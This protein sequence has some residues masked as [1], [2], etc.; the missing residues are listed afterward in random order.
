MIRLLL[1]LILSLAFAAQSVAMTLP[2][3]TDKSAFT[4][5]TDGVQ[6]MGGCYNATRGG[7]VTEDYASCARITNQGDLQVS[8]TDAGGTTA[9]DSTAHAAKVLVVDSTGTAIT[10]SAI[11][12]EAATF[13]T[14]D[15]NVLKT[16][17]YMFGYNSDS[18]ATQW[19]RFA[20]Q[21]ADFDTG[22]GTENLSLIGIGIP[23]SGGPVIGGTA[24]NPF[25]TS[26]A[27]SGTWTVQPGNTANTTAWLTSVVPPTSGGTSA[28]YITSAATTNATN[29]KASAGQLYGYEAVNTTA[30]LYYLRLYNL[31]SAP[32]CS[33]ATGFIRTIPI[34]ASTTGAGIQRSI[35][36]GEAYGTGIG[37]CL[38][39]GG[40]STDNTSAATGV[41]LTLNYK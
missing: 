33:S 2:F 34:P 11:G 25:S 15:T 35:D 4:E 38:T 16:I 1:P 7:S 30:T 26:A 8:L 37:F 3:K 24:T 21:P 20:F 12:T 40:S 29:C 31:A 28:C 41:Y 36:I 5:G 39:G 6:V 19:A 22:G 14:G 10:A 18:A 32:T 23:A 17:N 27:Q 9:M 13:S